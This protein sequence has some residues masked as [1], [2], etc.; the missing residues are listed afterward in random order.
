M[1]DDLT[2]LINGR[3]PQVFQVEDH[4]IFLL[5]EDGLNFSVNRRQPNFFCKWKTAKDNDFG[6]KKY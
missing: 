3:R 5:M 1:E 2:F 4:L 6:Q